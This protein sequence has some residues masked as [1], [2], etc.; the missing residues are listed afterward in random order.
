MLSAALPPLPAWRRKLRRLLGHRGLML[1]A[2]F[3]AIIVLAAIFAPLL[4]PH[5]PF[6]QDV[7]ARLIPP[8]DPARTAVSRGRRRSRGAR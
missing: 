8:A 1:G 4:A 2:L 6:E 5:D 7:T 3:L